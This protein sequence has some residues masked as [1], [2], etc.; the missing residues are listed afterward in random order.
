MKS[1][2]LVEEHSEEVTLVN[3]FS[4]WHLLHDSIATP[5]GGREPIV[6]GGTVRG[7]YREILRG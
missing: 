7:R 1:N 5:A 4:I 6:H 3:S 2:V